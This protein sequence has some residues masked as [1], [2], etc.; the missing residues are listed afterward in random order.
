VS[1]DTDAADHYFGFSDTCDRHGSVK[2]LQ[3]W[4]HSHD[5]WKPPR[6]LRPVPREPLHVL[7]RG[8]CEGSRRRAAVRSAWEHVPADARAVL[9]T[10]WSPRPK[11][12]WGAPWDRC[13]SRPWRWPKNPVTRAVE[14]KEARRKKAG[15]TRD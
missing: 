9:K 5:D 15:A 3:S 4:D 7:E 2:R 13:A 1:A 6:R 10:H 8:C 14:G 11:D 12:S